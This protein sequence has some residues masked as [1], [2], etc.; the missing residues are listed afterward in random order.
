MLFLL[1]PASTLPLHPTSSTTMAKAT[2]SHG[3]LYTFYQGGW[4]S[5]KDD[6]SPH[7]N[8]TGE[9][10]LADGKVEAI[11]SWSS[12]IKIDS[13]KLPLIKIDSRKWPHLKIDSRKWPHLKIDS[14]KLPHIQNNF[15]QAVN[16]KLILRK[17]AILDPKILITN[18]FWNI[19]KEPTIG[20]RKIIISPILSNWNHYS[21]CR[22]LMEAEGWRGNHEAP[23][24]PAA[25]PQDQEASWM[26]KFL[27]IFGNDDWYLI[28]MRILLLHSVLYQIGTLVFKYMHW[29][30]F[31][32]KL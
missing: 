14:H 17:I 22:V 24:H 7:R 16:P 27:V 8:Q 20:I 26:N 6:T 4:W 18:F 28:F 12:H 3:I 5:S 25:P 2:P 10:L 21:P 11:K 31:T 13:R 15:A 19:C 32:G 23:L 30:I 9:I 1:Q 29:I